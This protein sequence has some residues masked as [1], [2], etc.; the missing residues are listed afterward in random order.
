MSDRL[1]REFRAQLATTVESALRTI[2]LE[3]M[4]IFENSFQDHRMELVQKGEEV[5]QLKIKLQKLEIRLKDG[6]HGA[7][8]VEDR[9]TTLSD[10]L[11]RGPEAFPL[12][13]EQKSEIPEIDF[14]GS[15]KFTN[16]QNELHCF[17]GEGFLIAHYFVLLL[18]VPD[19]WCAPLGC[20]VVTKQEEGI[21][22]SVRLRQ[23]YIP[24]WRVHL[25]KQ[26]V[27]VFIL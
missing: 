5:A 26:E 15:V 20:E 14:E 23:L 8:R 11:K 12:T 22:P 10:H 19:D 4:N 18:E 27:C 1:S 13:S 7:D 21:C 17:F 2:K 16:V 3:I 9:T 25:T 6:K 24:L